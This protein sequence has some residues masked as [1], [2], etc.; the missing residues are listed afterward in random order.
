MSTMLVLT[1]LNF[2]KIFV[3]EC[4]ASGTNL[5]QSSCKKED[6][7]QTFDSLKH[8]M[9]TEEFLNSFINLFGT[10]HTHIYTQMTE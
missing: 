4:D 2:D 1:M 10:H 5:V 7:Q 3:V 9:S 8:A 6:S